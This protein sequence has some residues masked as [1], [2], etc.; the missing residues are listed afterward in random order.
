MVTYEG[1]IECRVAA[2]VL[3]QPIERTHGLTNQLRGDGSAD[4]M[5]AVWLAAVW[6]EPKPAATR[7]LWD[8]C[9]PLGANLWTPYGDRSRIFTKHHQLQLEES[10]KHQ[11]KSQVKPPDQCKSS[12]FY[13]F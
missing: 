1:P 2:G 5:S 9:P 13:M 12:F 7:P 10:I 6:L 3:V 11:F 8:G 4:D